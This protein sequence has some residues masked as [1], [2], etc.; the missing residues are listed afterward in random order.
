MPFGALEE[1]IVLD[2][3][4]RLAASFCAKTL[5]LYGCEVIKVESLVGETLRSRGS[6]SPASYPF[7]N[8]NTNKQC[9]TLAEVL[10]SSGYGTYGVGKWHVGYEEKPTE[11][12][13][14]EYYGYIRGHSTSQ[15]KVGNYMRLP[16][17]KKPELDFDADDFYATDAFNDYAVEFLEQ[18]QKASVAGVADL[19]DAVDGLSSVINAIT[20]STVGLFEGFGGE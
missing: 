1:I 18:A 7:A 6:S 12:G 14:D 17:G 3:S 15:W 19:G 2:L 11:R 4:D 10:K 20:L 13:F 9:M 16:E 8:L 5:G